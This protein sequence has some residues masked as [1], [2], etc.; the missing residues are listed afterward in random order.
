MFI[1]VTLIFLAGNLG[2]E[3]ISVDMKK[4]C[5]GKLQICIGP[6]REM[7]G[8]LKVLSVDVDKCALVINQA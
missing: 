1:F 4:S 8:S 5:D 2:D 6:G 7:E 3:V